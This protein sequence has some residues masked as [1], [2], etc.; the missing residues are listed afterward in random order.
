MNFIVNLIFLPDKN[1]NIS[2]KKH[3]SSQ[4]WKM[5]FWRRRKQG[6]SEF[7]TKAAAKMQLGLTIDDNEAAKRRKQNILPK[8]AKCKQSILKKKPKNFGQSLPGKGK[9]S[10]KQKS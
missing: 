4:M 5:H 10:I 9:S 8:A 6:T 1:V 7:S 2:N 3:F